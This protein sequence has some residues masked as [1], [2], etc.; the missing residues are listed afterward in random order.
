MFRSFVWLAVVVSHCER[1][2]FDRYHFELHTVQHETDS[3]SFLC[4]AADCIVGS[5][6]LFNIFH[7]FRY[8]IPGIAFCATD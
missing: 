2:A 3:I 8:F 1:A 6:F 4:M 7:L 5:S